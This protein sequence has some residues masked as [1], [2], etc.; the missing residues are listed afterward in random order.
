M[1]ATVYEREEV[2]EERKWL[3]LIPAQND[4]VQNEQ[5]ELQKI[6]AQKAAGKTEYVGCIFVNVAE[7]IIGVCRN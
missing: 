4:S 3:D 2:N 1:T 7:N 6:I 5:A